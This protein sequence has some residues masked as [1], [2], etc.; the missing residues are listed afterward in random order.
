ML[1]REDD[2]RKPKR[3]CAIF[4]CATNP[5]SQAIVT[6]FESGQKLYPV[7]K[8]RDVYHV[9]NETKEKKWFTIKDLY[10]QYFFLHRIIP[11]FEDYY[12]GE[13]DLESLLD[14]EID[15]SDKNFIIKGVV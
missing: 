6:L 15:F 11:I 5:N 1:Q 2:M 13:L 14:T 4:K 7:V 3:N 10:N 12:S 9:G 8:F